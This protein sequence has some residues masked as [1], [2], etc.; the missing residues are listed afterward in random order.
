MI[1]CFAAKNENVTAIYP[2]HT[3]LQIAEQMPSYTVLP[4]SETL[5]SL[6]VC[7][8]L[9]QGFMYLHVSITS[10]VSGWTP[11]SSNRVRLLCTVGAQLIY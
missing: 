5:N 4:D 7:F 3:S 9:I 8:R 6:Y 1:E 11:Y 10:H 2:C